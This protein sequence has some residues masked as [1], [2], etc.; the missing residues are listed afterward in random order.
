MQ[1]LFFLLWMCDRISVSISMFLYVI[2][3]NFILTIINQSEQFLP[4][5]IAL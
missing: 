3:I 4:I 1:F 5:I 2:I